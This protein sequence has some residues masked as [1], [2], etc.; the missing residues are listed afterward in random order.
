M[1]A[2]YNFSDAVGQGAGLKNSGQYM[3]EKFFEDVVNLP[4]LAYGAGK[5]GVDKIRG[6]D[7]KFETPY[8]AT[9]ARTGLQENLEQCLNHKNLEILQTKILMLEL[10][11]G[12]RMVDD[13]EIPALNRNEIEK[14]KDKN[15]ESNGSIL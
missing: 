6:K 12:M 14:A 7:A 10:V 8:E 3:V 13:M 4:G 5:F 1:F 9:F 11:Q 15:I 2:A